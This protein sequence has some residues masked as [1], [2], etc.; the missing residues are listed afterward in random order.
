[1]ICMVA[2]MFVFCSSVQA[3][4][5]NV[6]GDFDTIQDAIDS[7]D[8]SDGDTI[9]VLPGNHAGA[10]VTKS[11]EIRGDGG[12]VIDDGP[13][14]PAG[15][16]MGFRMLAG[17]DGA[18]ISHLGFTVDLAIMNGAA[19]SDVTVDQCTFT[20]AI[21]AVSNWCGNG[22]NISH[23]VI[24]D[25]R[26]SGG[27]GIGIL[28]ADYTGGVVTG[29]T[30]SHNTITGTLHV[31]GSGGY[32]G[33]G[34]VLYAD[35]RWGRL[36]AEEISGNRVMKNKISLESDTPDVV[37][38]VAIELTDTR[39]D[40]TLD[41]VLYD[42]TISFNDIRG[43]VWKVGLTPESLA[44]ENAFMRNLG[45]DWPGSEVATPLNSGSLGP[46]GPQ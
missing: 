42:N 26:A 28:V 44:D 36:G 4:T 7:D 17:S 15:L 33:T 5:W 37:D 32:C 21:Q 38:V 27:G 34:V 45:F 18:T 3:V 41:P 6:P 2:A 1:M 13:L 14:H 19:V 20:N 10:Y 30:V 46:F 23:N 8:V 11:V 31:S 39:N 12:A 22:W 16:T 9:H 35:F 24:T 25:L 40:G 29:N 43:T